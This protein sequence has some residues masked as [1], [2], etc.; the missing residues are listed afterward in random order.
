MANNRHDGNVQSKQRGVN[1]DQVAQLEQNL[2]FLQDQHQATLDAL[3]QEVETLR[4][5]NRGQSSILKVFVLMFMECF[6]LLVFV[7][8]RFAVS[9]SIFKELSQRIEQFEFARRE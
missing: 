4:Q 1:G 9:V 8:S 2:K 7:F 3:H 6:N 5:K